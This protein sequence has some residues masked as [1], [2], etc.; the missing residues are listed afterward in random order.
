[1]PLSFRLLA[2]GALLAVAA[3][4]AADIRP[5][6][7]DDGL[8]ITY[9]AEGAEEEIPAGVRCIIRD[10][11]TIGGRDYIFAE[12]VDFRSPARGLDHIA[13][14]REAVARSQT[15]Y[16]AFF[17]L[18][19]ATIFFGAAPASGS[20]DLGITNGTADNCVV[21]IDDG[22]LAGLEAGDSAANQLRRTIEHE[23]FHCSQEAHPTLSRAVYSRAEDGWWMEGSA[24]YFAGLAI[25]EALPGSP[26][27]G[28]FVAGIFAQ[29]LYS[30]DYNGYVFFA[31]LGRTRGTEAVVSLLHNVDTTHGETSEQTL[32]QSIPDFDRL[33]NQFARALFDG[34]QDETGRMLPIEPPDVDAT[35][36]TGD[37]RVTRNVIPFAFGAR[38]FSAEENSQ[39]RFDAPEFD[40]PLEASLAD[41][42]G[43]WRELPTRFGSCQHEADA[44]LVY[45][46]TSRRSGSQRATFPIFAE[47]SIRLTDCPCPIGAWTVSS[48]NMQSMSPTER[49]QV[50]DPGR[51]SMVF[52][53]DGTA[54]FNVEGFVS[55]RTE[56]V[57]GVGTAVTTIER[58]YV[59]SWNWTVRDGFLIMNETEDMTITETQSA[60]FG[61]TSRTNPPRRRVVATNASSGRSRRFACEGNQLTIGPPVVSVGSRTMENDARNL[62]Y[63]HWGVFERQ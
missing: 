38:R 33:F 54:H 5:A 6:S 51:V 44:I 15:I 39:Y 41:T 40:G 9:A 19:R 52:S 30:L 45:T 1:V 3:L 12:F 24:E 34:L 21:Y 59:A 60:S 53:A 14:A 17:P 16:D 10:A 62:N 50:T 42:P 48:E 20:D 2:C 11:P 43:A 28:G 26:F 32:L 8:C 58:D 55:R 35:V 49:H 46:S 29:P 18:P 4:L 63:P 56:D 25:S 61:S 27:Y 31:Y 57:P 47:D 36:L 13:I 37:T 23:L 22:A 7:A